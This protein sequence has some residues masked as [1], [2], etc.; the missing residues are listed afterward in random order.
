MF[1]ILQEH[2]FAVAGID[3]GE[4]YGSPQGRRLYQAF[5]QELTSNR[6]FASRPV[7]LARCRGGLMLYSWANQHPKS[8]GGIAGI[9]PVCNLTSYP[10]VNRAA[11]AF[12]LTPEQLQERLKELNPIEQLQSL[13][14]AKVP[15]FHIQGLCP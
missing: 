15:I 9:Y 1:T 14:K 10:G 11:P 12:G 13:A 5:Y 7:L 3:V 2:G 8:V 6:R 4:S